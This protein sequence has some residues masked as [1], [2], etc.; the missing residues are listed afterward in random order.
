[1]GRNTLIA[2][3]AVCALACGEKDSGTTGGVED[4]GTPVAEVNSSGD[5]NSD[6]E[7]KKARLGRNAVSTA[8]AAGTLSSSNYKMTLVVGAAAPM[9][10]LPQKS[11]KYRV[12]IGTPIVESP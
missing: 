11:D 5:S 3:F 8:G 6:T 4:N 7:L 2:V 1:M 10:T 12:L 9:A